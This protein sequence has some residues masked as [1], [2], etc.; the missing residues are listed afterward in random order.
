MA[1][2]SS[3]DPCFR[4]DNTSDKQAAKYCVD[5]EDKL[6]FDCIRAHK[7]SKASFNHHIIHLDV[8]YSLPEESI[9]SKRICKR[10]SDFIMDFFCTF[11]DTLCCRNCIADDHRSCDKVVPL[12]KAAEG[13]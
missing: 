9:A 3:C 11:H 4:I 7:G 12:E 5:C 2:G 8:A 13:V 1:T 6:C 10:H